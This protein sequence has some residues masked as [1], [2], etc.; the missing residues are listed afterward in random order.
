M[1]VI[2]AIDIRQ[3]KS[4]MLTRGLVE[5]ETIYS[6]D[7][8][9]VAESFVKDGAERLHIVDLDAALSFDKNND[10]NRDVILSVRKSVKDSVIE[11]GGGIRTAD[12]ARRIASAGFDYIIMGTAVIKNPEEFRRA[13]DALPGRVMAACD[14]K[15]SSDSPE[16]MINGWRE[17]ASLKIEELLERCRAVPTA[18]KTIIV[19]D[20]SNDGTLGGV[21][22]EFYMRLAALFVRYGF[23]II[24][25][26]GV[27]AL[28]DIIKLKSAAAELRKRFKTD[29]DII[30][31][32]IVGKALY[33]K[34]FTVKEAIAACGSGL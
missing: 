19:T 15:D 1:I 24:V 28:E 6:D 16:V 17:G 5:G 2:P 4:V 13:S 29:E 20:V 12:S 14:V 27:A 21:N 18:R 33:E 34:R 32:V 10:V 25:S 22:V 7:A 23:K 11:I 9:R 3:K 8:S 30:E 31:G 26:G